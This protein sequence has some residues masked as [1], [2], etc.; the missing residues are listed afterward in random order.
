MDHVAED[1]LGITKKS[2]SHVSYD[3]PGWRITDNDGN[4]IPSEKL[5]FNIVKKTRK[6]VYGILHMIVTEEQQ[7]KFL[8]INAAPVLDEHDNFLYMV[9]SIEDITQKKQDEIE[10]DT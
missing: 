7:K 9:A 10:L 2:I 1:I 3:D 5:P 6:N 4:P 8:H